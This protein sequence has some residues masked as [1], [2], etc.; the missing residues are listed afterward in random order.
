M[1]D[2]QYEYRSGYFAAL[3]SSRSACAEALRSRV[4]EANAENHG[5]F[6]RGLRDGL[7]LARDLID[8]AIKKARDE[9]KLKEERC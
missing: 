7:D 3:S 9:L 8:K 5:E 6:S 4:S 2:A 1:T